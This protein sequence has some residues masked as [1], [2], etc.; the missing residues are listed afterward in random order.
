MARTGSWYRDKRRPH[1]RLGF[2]IS[3]TGVRYLGRGTPIP[4]GGAS[5]ARFSGSWSTPPVIGTI[6]TTRNT[7]DAL[8]MLEPGNGLLTGL[9]AD[10]PVTRCCSK[11]LWD[12]SINPASGKR[13][14]DHRYRSSGPRPPI[15]S[16]RRPAIQQLQTRDTSLAGSSPAAPAPSPRGSRPSSAG[17]GVSHRRA[18]R[19]R[20]CRWR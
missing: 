8:T 17:C 15:T 20:R 5:A 14:L 7:C 13:Y 9:S 19:P 16:W 11:S 3:L 2:P 10:T 6:G 18:S 4:G 12:G 1:D